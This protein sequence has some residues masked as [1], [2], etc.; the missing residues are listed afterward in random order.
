MTATSC[1]NVVEFLQ[2]YGFFGECDYL[3]G[4]LFSDVAFACRICGEA[5]IKG[6]GII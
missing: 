3:Q 2:I 1:L 5:I 6:W 4:L